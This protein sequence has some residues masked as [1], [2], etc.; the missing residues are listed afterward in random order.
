MAGFD[1]SQRRHAILRNF[2]VLGHLRYALE[3]IGSGPRQYIVTS[4][5]EER[6][7]SR[8]RRRWIYASA[9]R[10]N[11]YFAFGTSQNLEASLNYLIIPPPSR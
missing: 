2:P 10:Q 6:P 7:Y 3:E 11:N 5:T 8:D 1:L 4:N 9:K